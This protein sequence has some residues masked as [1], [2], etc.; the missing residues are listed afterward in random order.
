MSLFQLQSWVKIIFLVSLWLRASVR[1]FVGHWGSW[2]LILL[3]VFTGGKKGATPII[4]FD[5]WEQEQQGDG[6]SRRNYKNKQHASVWRGVGGAVHHVLEQRMYT[7]SHNVLTH[8]NSLQ[9]LH[10]SDFNPV[11]YTHVYYDKHNLSVSRYHSLSL[12]CSFSAGWGVLILLRPVRT[13]PTTGQT[14]LATPPPPTPRS[15]V[16]TQEKRVTVFACLVVSA[17]PSWTIPGF[18]EGGE[19]SYEAPRWPFVLYQ[20]GTVWC[21]ENPV[22]CFF[23]T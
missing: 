6:V 9:A 19:I 4:L 16:L 2:K 1:L 14:T 17:K 10:V 20:D 22:L 11:H 23:Q 5:S 3:I 21:W 7:H 12:C 18:T 15:E 8:A 13:N